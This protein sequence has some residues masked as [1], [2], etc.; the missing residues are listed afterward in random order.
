MF[1]AAGQELLKRFKRIYRKE[2]EIGVEIERPPEKKTPKSKEDQSSINEGLTATPLG[3]P[4]DFVE[5][6][7]IE[8]LSLWQRFEQL[9]PED[10]LTVEA[11]MDAGG[12]QKIASENLG[13]EY[14]TIR[15][16]ISR[17]SKR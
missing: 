12:D 4:E 10:Q 1:G 14:G 13:I 15:K 16:R 7:R 11:L 9:S 2:A 8:P 5:Y 17:M 3:A 6:D